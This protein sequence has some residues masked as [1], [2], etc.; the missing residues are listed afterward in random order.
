MT[1]ERLEGLVGAIRE[2]LDDRHAARERAVDVSRQAIRHAGNAIRAA[3]RGEDARAAELIAAS[4]AKVVEAREATAEHPDLAGSGLVADA[5]KEYAEACLTRA[6]LRGDEL[7]G[8]DELGVSDTAWLGGFAEAIGE[9]RRAAL[10]RLRSGDLDEAERLVE[11]M[12]TAYGLLVTIDYPEGVTGGLRRSTDVARG[13]LERT[14]GDVTTARLQERLR[15]ALD[16]HRRDVL[17]Q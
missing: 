16:A 12:D 6:A 5:E 4:L 1:G 9:Q 8:P 7:P 13:I 11:Q 14:R 17:D 15:A 2:R 3:H 10:D